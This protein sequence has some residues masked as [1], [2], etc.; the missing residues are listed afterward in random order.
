MYKI[1][2]ISDIHIDTNKVFEVKET[3]NLICK[4][5]NIDYLIIAGDISSRANQ[6]TAFIEWFSRNSNTKIKFVSGNHDFYNFTMSEGGKTVERYGN[7]AYDI[8]EQYDEFL[9][10]HPLV[11][12]EYVILGNCGWYNYSYSE[13]RDILE[14]DKDELSSHERKLYKN[15][16]KQSYK[17]NRWA[18][19]KYF[20]WLKNDNEKLSP[21]EIA[22]IFLKKLEEQLKKYQD[23]KIIAISHMVP[24]YHFVT[25]KNFDMGWNFFNSYIG[26]ERIGELYKKYGVEM[27]V[28][29]HTHTKYDE[30]YEGIRC[31]C[32]PLG[33]QFVGEWDNPN[34]VYEEIFNKLTVIEI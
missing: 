22:D 18:D 30:V 13:Y 26:D 5:N 16:I 23:K 1:A 11:L 15:V 14:K 20:N 27:C 4:E 7:D 32:S 9:D 29:G 3:L 25:K 34:S 19:A 12:D 28:F 17:G 31:I 8:F 21:P 2:F 24:F 33:Y 10:N 6:T